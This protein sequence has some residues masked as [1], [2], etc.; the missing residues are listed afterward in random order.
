ML[1][2]EAALP[3]TN[4]QHVWPLLA[5]AAADDLADARRANTSIAATVW[6]SSLTRM[7]KALMS[8]G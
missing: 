5:L 7:K 4:I 6:P 3:H 2:V 8:L 1:L